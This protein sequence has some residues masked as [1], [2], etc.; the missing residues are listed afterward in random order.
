MKIKATTALMFLVTA[1]L[2]FARVKYGFGL[3]DGR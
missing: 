3:Q 2:F 1:A